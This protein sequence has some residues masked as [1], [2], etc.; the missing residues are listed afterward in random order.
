MS[1]RQSVLW[2]VVTTVALSFG[3]YFLPLPA[4][5]KSLLVPILLAFLPTAVAVLIALLT[6]GKAGMLQLFSSVLGA[7]RWILIGATLGAFL[8]VA[9]LALGILLGAS[10]HPDFSAP[11]TIFI[12]LVTIP[13]AWFEEVG[14]RRFAL[15]RLLKS[16]SPMDASLLLGIPW[17]LIHLILLW[18]GMMSVGAPAIPQVG[19]LVALSV[20]LTWAYVRSGGSLF[21][22]TLL[23]GVQ[24]GLVVLNR[25]VSIVEGTW[26]MM[27]VYVLVAVLLIIF[28]RH[29]FFAKQAPILQ[30]GGS[31]A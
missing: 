18:P 23:H 21:T 13:F 26:L 16:H 3:A 2:F 30:R 24:N 10:I 9:V 20:V 11:G 15:D 7:G 31:M 5:T 4:E 27:G 12:I 22:V 29:M 1:K 8:R 17:A 14:W 28:E 19:V 25:G 6:E